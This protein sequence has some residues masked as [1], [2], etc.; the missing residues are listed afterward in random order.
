MSKKKS[1]L[2]W[3]WIIAGILIIYFGISRN[4]K[5]EQRNQLTKIS[6]ELSNDITNVKGRKSTID[7]KFWTI[8][9]K[10]QFNILKGS[11][12]RGKH[13]IVSELKKGQAIELYIEKSDENKLDIKTN[14]ITICGLNIDGKSVISTNEYYK[15]RKYYKLRLIIVGLFLG[16]MFLLNGLFSISSKVNYTVIGLFIAAIFIMRY[17]H[18]II[19]K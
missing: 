9:Y 13:S 1:G 19:Y 8:E 6:I 3:Y 17:F 16:L 7:Y 4:G 2:N 12:T 18:I 15:N 5:V 14:E 11:I 10:A